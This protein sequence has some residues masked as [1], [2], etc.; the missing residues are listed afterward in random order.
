M[1][2]STGLAGRLAVE[3]V[4]GSWDA[5]RD[6]ASRAEEVTAAN[7][8]FPC[9]FNWRNL[10]VSALGLAQLGDERG[11]RRLEAIGRSTAVVMP[12]AERE[13][14]LLRLALL[15]ADRDEMRRILELLPVGD[16]KFGIDGP[17]ARLDAL[18]ALGETER[19][20]E[21][22]ALYVEADGY[23]RAFALRAL[24]VS[25]RDASLVREAVACFE[26]MGLGWRAEETTRLAKSSTPAPS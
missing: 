15:R 11:A 16:D 22:A 10:L 14:A 7:V 19:L 3:S 9:Q 25:R 21:E 4:L 17:A 1:T 24:G 8:D 23:T 6:L 18:L 26:R 12:P 20:E 2:A 5:V 13:P